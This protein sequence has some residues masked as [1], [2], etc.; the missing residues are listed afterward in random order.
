MIVRVQVAHAS[1][2]NYMTTVSSKAQRE[3]SRRRVESVG[4]APIGTGNI[5]IRFLPSLTFESNKLF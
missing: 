5:N 2:K 1:L 3:M 4:V